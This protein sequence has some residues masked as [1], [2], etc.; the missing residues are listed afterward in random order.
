MEFGGENAGKYENRLAEVPLNLSP[1]GSVSE[2]N[3]NL[4]GVE[5]YYGRRQEKVSKRLTEEDYSTDFTLDTGSPN[6]YVPTV[7]YESI[8]DGLN[9]T[10]IINGAPYVPCS[11]RSMRAG[12][13]TFEFA[14]RK[15]GEIAKIRVPYSEII[16]PPGFPVTVP[17]V[18]D[19]NGEEL[20]YFGIVPTDGPV[21]LLGAT[22]LR[23]AYVVFEADKKEL[24]LAQSKPDDCGNIMELS[25]GYCD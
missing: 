13:L 1:D 14:M 5:R 12:Y 17:L 6:M 11:L 23:S 4:T 24:R 22:F 2:W 3:V 16:Y 21:R 9:A 20:C 25:G 8:V 18:G 15:R 10:E 19:R 7:L